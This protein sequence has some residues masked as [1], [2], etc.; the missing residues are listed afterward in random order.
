MW[1]H[2]FSKS[3]FHILAYQVLCKSIGLFWNRNRNC[4]NALSLAASLFLVQCL[5]N[6]SLDETLSLSHWAGKIGQHFCK[7]FGKQCSLYLKLFGFVIFIELFNSYYTMHQLL[8]NQRKLYSKWYK[9]TAF[10]TLID[11]VYGFKV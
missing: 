10:W 6:L 2:S 1:M 4:T 3:P 9:N 8:N 5:I 11:G 7:I